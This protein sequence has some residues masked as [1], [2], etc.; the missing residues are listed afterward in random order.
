MSPV[1]MFS[2]KNRTDPSAKSPFTPPKWL[3]LG[4]MPVCFTLMALNFLRFVFGEETLHTG[5]AGVHE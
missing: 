4:A 1:S 3:L 2:L 5:E